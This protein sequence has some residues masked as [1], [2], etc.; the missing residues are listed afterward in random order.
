MQIKDQ[1]RES[2]DYIILGAGVAGLSFAHEVAKNGNSVL[3]LEKAKV[4]GGLSQTLEYKGFLFDYC[5]H[6]FI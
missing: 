6:C 4:I 3:I 5:S 1:L 2:Y